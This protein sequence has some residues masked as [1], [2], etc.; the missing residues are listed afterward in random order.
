MRGELT[1]EGRLIDSSNN[2]ML[3]IATADGR[4]VRCVY[5]PIRGERPLWDFPDGTLA[6]REVAA[7]VVSE[8]AG[9]HCVPATVFRNGEFGPGMVQ[10][11]IA[12]PDAPELVD[13]FPVGA[14]P[15]GW[16]PVLALEDTDGSP[17]VL[18]HRDST[19]LAEVA[20]FDAVTNNADRKASH[21]LATADGRVLGVDHGLTFHTEPKLRTILW[22]WAGQPI[23]PQLVEGLERLSTAFQGDLRDQLTPH[24][25]DAE[26]SEFGRRIDSL[27]ETPQ[28][29][30][31]PTDR[32]AIPWPPL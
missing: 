10:E 23:A 28:F 3:A 5:K 18:A 12:E 24:L 1:L 25:S 26:I 19:A 6:H 17:L 11:W 2:A 13:I 9:W 7:S 31:P 15:A 30:S 20:L 29:P 32:H 22:G 27:L 16:L 8:A 14:Q 21:L 4:S